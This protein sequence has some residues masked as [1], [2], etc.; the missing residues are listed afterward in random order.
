[1]KVTN[2]KTENSQVFLSI[3]MEAAEM[4]EALEKSYR[5][6]VKKANIPG[7]R[8][9]KAPRDLLE[10]Y[11]GKESL[12]EDA[13]NKMIPEAYERALK[14]QEI[15]AFAQP[16]IEVTQT[17][18][19]IFKATVPVRPT[20]TLGDY[21]SIKV[22]PEPVEL[23]E[24]NINAVIDRLQHQQATW[25]PVERPVA[26]DDLVVLDIESSIEEEPFLN[27]KG[28]QYWVRRDI[29]LPAPGFAEQLPEMKKDEDKEFKLQISSDYPQS[30]MA[31]KELR[32]KVTV[33]E[34]KEEKLPELNDELAKQI[35]PEFETVAMLREKVSAELKQQAEEKAKI[36]FEERVIQ[37]VVDLAQ[38]EFPPI[39]VEMETDRLINEQSR[40][41]QMSGHRLEEYLNG[42]NKTEEEL[43]EELKP[44]ANKRITDSLVLEKVSEEE[45]IEIS[46]AEIDAEIE[47][48]LKDAGEN[49]DELRKYLNTPQSKES[50]KQILVTRKTVQRLVEIAKGES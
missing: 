11:L 17:D 42:I 10:R 36:D 50:I 44:R 7:F 39:L 21:H 35:N 9:G 41:L 27:R 43:R 24:D 19:V 48:M 2:E 12:I 14:E 20:V 29:P 15:D 13:L 30:E 3:E 18:P 33:T 32:F 40:R 47:E 4:E 37:E 5:R 23:T 1:M 25:E 28:F 45:K 49:T 26:F 16:H 31:G 34:I 6:L 38:V 46:D 22:A 8:K